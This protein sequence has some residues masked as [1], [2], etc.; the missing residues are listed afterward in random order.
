MPPGPRSIPRSSDARRPKRSAAADPPSLDPVVVKA[1]GDLVALSAAIRACGTCVPTGARYSLGSGYPRAPV[2]LLSEHPEA[3]DVES[4]IAFTD[5][6]PPLDKAFG[7]LGMSLSWVYGTTA[8][9][10]LPQDGGGVCPEHLAVE[11]EAVDPRV[12]V[13][14]GPRAVEALRAV[15]GRCGLAVPDEVPQGTPVPLRIGL[16][17]VATEPLPAGVTQADAKRRLWRDLRQ[18]PSLVDRA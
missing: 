1:A 16:V 11:I 12:L 18:L 17:L 5:V 7:A 9:R 8:R 4:G 6:A 3:A 10:T 13:A 14:F 2:M 15:H